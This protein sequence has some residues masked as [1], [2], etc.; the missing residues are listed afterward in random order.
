[1]RQMQIQRKITRKQKYKKIRNSTKKHTC[2]CNAFAVDKPI[3]TVAT[4]LETSR[5]I[6]TVLVARVYITLVNI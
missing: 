4:A 1:M 2:F 5:D 6:C 3:F